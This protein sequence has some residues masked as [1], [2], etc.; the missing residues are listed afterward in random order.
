MY[1]S[2]ILSYPA[3]QSLTGLAAEAPLTS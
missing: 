3:Y 2:G 1:D